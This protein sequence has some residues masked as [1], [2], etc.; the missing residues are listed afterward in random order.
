M[1]LSIGNRSS[2]EEGV[3][4]IHHALDQG[5]ALID[6]AS[7][8]CKDDSDSIAEWLESLAVSFTTQ[9]VEQIDRVLP[10]QLRTKVKA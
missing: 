10:Q 3:A 9:E 7:C 1:H 4:V 5:N 8:Y 6:T 2:G